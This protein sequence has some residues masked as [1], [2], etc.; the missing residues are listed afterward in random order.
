LPGLLLIP[1]YLLVLR[2]AGISSKNKEL[3]E[4]L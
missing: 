1:C 2:A 3:Q 4:R